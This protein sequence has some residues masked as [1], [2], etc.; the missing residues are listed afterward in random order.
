[1]PLHPQAQQ[2]LEYMN[3]IQ[4]P[5]G[6]DTD[7]VEARANLEQLASVV[8][9]EL[10]E[11]VLH[12]EDRVVPGPRGNIPLRIYRPSDDPELPV[13]VWFHGGGFVTG[14]IETHDGILR[15]VANAAGCIVVSVDYGLAPEV[16]FPGGVEDC[17][18]AT[19][20]VAAH[21]GDFGGD[22][23]RIAVGGDS[24]GGNLAAVIALE[25]K[26]SGGPDLVFQLLLYP[27]TTYDP[28]SPSIKENATGY[29]LEESD[30]I[31]FSGHYFGSE[32]HAIALHEAGE[33]RAYPLI[34][35]DL[36]GLPPALV[37]T[38]EF[39]PLRDQGEDYARR[40]AAS[41]VNTRLQRYEGMF[42]GFFGMQR[43]LD[44]SQVLF[45]DVV[46]ALRHAFGTA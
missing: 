37:A 45:D 32:Q 38:A 16:P 23:T 13:L 17:W 12:V 4:E 27:V 2:L 19:Q 29:F 20:W 6:P 34:A 9:V 35:P 8:P 10:R 40:L 18:I 26:A 36:T 21:A 25:A 11:Q 15:P 39:D 42:H 3:G 24:A 41:G 44:T 22:A 30:M 43:V 28:E 31:W 14:S 33:W 1:M 46:T 7:P 5:Y